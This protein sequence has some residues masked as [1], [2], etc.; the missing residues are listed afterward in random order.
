MHAPEVHF[1]IGA[2]SPY[3]W[4]TAERIDELLPQAQWHGVLLQAIFRA[5]E[6]TSWGLTAEREQG[7][8]ESEQRAAAHGLGPIRWPDPWPTSDLLI[9]RAMTHAEQLGRLREFALA[10][11]RLEFLEGA[12]LS[13][14]D[15]VRE[16]ATRS[17]LDA[18]ELQHAVRDPAVKDALRAHRRGARRGRVRSAVGDRRRA[19]VLG[20]RPP[21]R[22]RRRGARSERL[23]G[24]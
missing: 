18:D 14:P 13:E 2:M 20:R 23:S 16:A 11:M 6:R 24:I 21:A 10:A 15:A 8:A 3:T 22:R 19:A 12:V 9:A 1:Y 4:I 7:I 5:R 17:G